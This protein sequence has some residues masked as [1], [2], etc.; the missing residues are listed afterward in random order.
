MINQE[1]IVLTNDQ[2]VNAEVLWR[3][4]H[5]VLD[6]ARDV[7]PGLSV[8]RKQAFADVE[9]A[10]HVLRNAAIDSED[11]TRPDSQASE[12]AQQL[13]AD[14]LNKTTRGRERF[15]R[16][17]RA[18]RLLRTLMLQSEQQYIR[19]RIGQDIQ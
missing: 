18:G 12:I 8:G 9:P 13:I 19:E 2:W 6:A 4:S 7:A 15:V 14:N 5:V 10:L 3:T 17:W 1:T 16:Q 11:T